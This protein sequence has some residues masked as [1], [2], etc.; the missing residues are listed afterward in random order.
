MWFAVSVLRSPAAKL[1]T[2]WSHTMTLPGMKASPSSSLGLTAWV[3][4]W[5][6]C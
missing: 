4:M 2:S 1:S 5:R 3:T 6:R